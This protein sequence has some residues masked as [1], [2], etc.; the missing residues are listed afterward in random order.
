VNTAIL[1]AF[2]G[3]QHFVVG[4]KPHHAS[5]VSAVNLRD[6]LPNPP[7]EGMGYYAQGLEVKYKYNPKKGFWENARGTH[8]K[9]T[10]GLSNR[11]VFGDLPA[12]LLMD[13]NIY[14][15]LNYKK[16]G[17]LV[18]PDSPSYQKLYAFSQREDVV[19][20]LLKRAKMETLETK[21]L[22]PAITNLG[23]LDFPSTYG[24]LELDRLIMQPGGAFPLVHVD[25]VIGALTCAGKL[26]LVVEYAPEAMH[27]AT[28]TEI[29]DKA[30]ELLFSE[31]A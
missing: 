4:E 14:A 7:G 10:A 2:S 6:R 20:R 12:F 16:L 22:G 19:V 29:K 25:M 30:I 5:T 24:N 17:A 8:K 3:A 31:A 18:S 23:R 1:T 15:A 9:I 13:S 28:M 27:T 21:L 11:K 26:S